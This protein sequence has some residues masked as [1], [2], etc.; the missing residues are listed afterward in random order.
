[1]SPNLPQNSQHD[2]KV[3][4]DKDDYNN[5]NVLTFHHPT[6]IDSQIGMVKVTEQEA[7]DAGA[8]GCS[9]CFDDVQATNYQFP[10]KSENGEVLA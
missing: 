3:L 8:V 4:V 10:Y 7:R 2:T 6:Q 1:M 9:K 5:G